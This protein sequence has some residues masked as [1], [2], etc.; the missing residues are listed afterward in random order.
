MRGRIPD[1]FIDELPRRDGS[2][3]HHRGKAIVEVEV[4]NPGVKPT[5]GVFLAGRDPAT[6]RRYFFPNSSLAAAT[7][8]SGSNPNF[9]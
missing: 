2:A 6:A 7:T 4:A 1:S 8:R 3:V 9:R 5:Q